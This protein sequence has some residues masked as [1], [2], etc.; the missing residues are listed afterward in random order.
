MAVAGQAARA[1]ISVLY[2]HSL[3]ILTL[4]ISQNGSYLVT[5]SALLGFQ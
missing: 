2:Q 4:T 5:A 1:S 3:L